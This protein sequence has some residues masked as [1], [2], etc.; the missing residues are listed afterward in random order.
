LKHWLLLSTVLILGAASSLFFYKKSDVASTTS[1]SAASLT[2]EK[3]E[4]QPLQ[5]VVYGKPKSADE[6]KYD[7]T[8]DLA[9]LLAEIKGKAESGDP[10]A[11]RIYGQIL[12][13]CQLTSVYPKYF[14]ELAETQGKI[15]PEFKKQYE[16]IAV[17]K[18]KRCARVAENTP[19]IS[20]PEAYLWYAKAA[21]KNDGVSTAKIISKMGP[22]KLDNAS[23]KEGIDKVVNSGDPEAI[24]VLAEIAGSRLQSRTDT[25]GPLF[26]G[27]AHEYGW[28]LAACRMGADCSPQGATARNL[29]LNGARSACT[30]T[31]G[32]QEIYRI[33]F[34]S[35]ADY[36][37][38][39][40]I[41]NEVVT[42]LK[43]PKE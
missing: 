39:L 26:G 3:S 8:E 40:N 9:S 32:L 35:P 34:M 25:V 21:M 13:E 16:S 42:Y 11:Q 37:N 19:R 20:T 6:L 36:Q 17:S 38:A 12:E 22:E 43:K 15:V 24:M 29:C 1:G 27:Q 31:L 33:D 30:G 4:D 14:Q 10:T 28:K 5:P 23:L 18:T 7:S 2:S 41:S